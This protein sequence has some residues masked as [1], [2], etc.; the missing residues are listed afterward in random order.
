M[1]GDSAFCN[2]PRVPSPAAIEGRASLSLTPRS[3]KHD[4]GETMIGMD[5]VAFLI[6]L[7]AAAVVSAILHY[8]CEYYVTP[9]PWSFGSKV[10]VAW[11]GAWLG[12][13]V[14]GHWWAGCQYQD[15][16]YVPAILGSRRRGY[17]G[18]RSRQ[19][20]GAQDRRRR[21][22]SRRGRR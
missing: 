12:S 10:I 13:P 1:A 9:G 21:K 18:G 4:Q 2:A 19:D 11:I 5:F 8:G 20:G 14:L 17:P 7:I 15:V 22:T 6:L 16:Y 3:P